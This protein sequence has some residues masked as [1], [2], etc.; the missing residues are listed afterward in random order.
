MPLALSAF[1]PVHDAFRLL[2]KNCGV[3]RNGRFRL[4]KRFVS[5]CETVRF[6]VRNGPYCKAKQTVQ[7]YSVSNRDFLF[8]ELLIVNLTLFNV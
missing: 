7:P 1:R 6:S 4:A 5:Q 3:V 8:V 2:R